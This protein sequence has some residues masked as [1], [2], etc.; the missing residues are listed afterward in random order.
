M[1]KKKKSVLKRQR[2][3]KKKT[4]RNKSGRARLK[5]TVKKIREK[6]RKNESATP[7][8]LTKVL[9]DLDKAVSRGLIHKNTAARKKSHLM[10][11]SR[12]HAVQ[13]SK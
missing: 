10:K 13:V 4:A 8:D 2:Q 1:A 3:D 5:T 12:K 11:L 6:V 7:V 9:R